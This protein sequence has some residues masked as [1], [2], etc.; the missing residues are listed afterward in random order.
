M[1]EQKNDQW[2][3]EYNE[4]LKNEQ[5]VPQEMSNQVFSKICGLLNPSAFM[6]FTKVFSIHLAVGTLSL[7]ICHQF[8]L[9]PFGTEKSLADWFMSVGGH[10]FCMIGCGILF[11]A[12]SIVA[13]GYFLTTEEVR[14][15]R[16]TEFLQSLCLSLFSL[17]VFAFFGAELVLTF[18]GLWLLGALIGGYAATEVVWR[19]KKV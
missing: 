8:G 11:T 10:S 9:N 18:A 2:L 3:K 6:I 19:F 14:V 12:L 16:R 5:P 1:N 13:A 7:A 15:L 4:F 17:G